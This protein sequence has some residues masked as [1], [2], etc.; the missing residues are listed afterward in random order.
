MTAYEIP[1]SPQN[2]QFT[3][4]LGGNTYQMTVRWNSVCGSWILDIADPPTTTSQAGAPI[5]SGIPMVTGIDLLE[6]FGYLRNWGGQLICQ[7]DY[8]PN[9]IATFE[10]LGITSHLYW[11][12][13]D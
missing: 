1:L 4:A 11:V 13:N 6:Q 2:Q 8:D 5:L 9:A 3:I 7:T 12:T 10:N